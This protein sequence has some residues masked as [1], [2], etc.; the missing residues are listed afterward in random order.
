MTFSH[1]VSPLNLKAHPDKN[2]YL[3][4][5]LIRLRD[6][7]VTAGKFYWVHDFLL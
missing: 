5:C 6:V 4:S 2:V 3:Q 7:K 1:F